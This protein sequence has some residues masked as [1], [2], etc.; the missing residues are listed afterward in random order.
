MDCLN[1]RLEFLGD[2][3]LDYMITAYT[4]SVYPNLK[5]GH[6]SDLRS[7]CVNNTSF[8]DVAGKWSFHEFIICDSI[9]LREAIT[10]YVSNIGRSGTG[11]DHFEEKACPKVV[12][13]T[14]F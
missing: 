5:P 2:A 7:A 11:D 13:C 10:K 1:Q 6:L 4:Y 14:V 12:F 9:V 8:A 3:V